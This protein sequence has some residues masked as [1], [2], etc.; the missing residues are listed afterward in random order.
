M[1]FFFSVRTGS[2]ISVSY[3]HP[4]RLGITEIKQQGDALL[5]YKKKFDMLQVSN[6]IKAMNGRVLLSAG[7]QPYISV[8][9]GPEAPLAVLTG[10]LKI[11][12][13][14]T[15]NDSDKT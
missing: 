15:E 3:T 7:S 14:T 5:I 12:E 2:T 8:K 9:I 4:S 10:I 1:A 11:M 13:Q 6:L